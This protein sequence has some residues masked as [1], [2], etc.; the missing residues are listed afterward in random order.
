VWTA[1]GALLCASILGASGPPVSGAEPDLF[2]Q[3]ER[4]LAPGAKAISIIDSRTV[5]CEMPDPESD[6]CEMRWEYLSVSAGSTGYVTFMAVKIDGHVRAISTG[7]FQT[8]MYIPFDM[9]F[10]PFAVQCGKLGS[11]GAPDLGM[12]HTYYIE[13]FDTTGALASNFGA[14]LCPASVLLFTDGFEGGDVSRWS[15]HTP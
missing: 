15:A 12:A 1:C 7:F 8:S 11:G 10:T 4:S 2:P 6:L 3:S 9:Y 13:A 14:V 5:Q